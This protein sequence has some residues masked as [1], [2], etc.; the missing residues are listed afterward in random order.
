MILALSYSLLVP[1]TS[2]L[3]VKL[4]DECQ[5]FLSTFLGP[6]RMKK[7]KLWVLDTVLPHS[8]RSLSDDVEVLH[9][10]SSKSHSEHSFTE[11]SVKV[12]CQSE[13]ALPHAL[14][15]LNF[16]M[17]S[18][19]SFLYKKHVAVELRMPTSSV[20]HPE[21]GFVELGFSPMD[22]ITRARGP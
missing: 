1:V 2:S 17:C 22:G 21:L 4:F 7:L 14:K 9:L 3:L 18:L 10:A 11:T 16:E 8:R 12:R 5:T 13:V 19:A 20:S 6:P 15:C